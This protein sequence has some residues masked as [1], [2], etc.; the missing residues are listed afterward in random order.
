VTGTLASTGDFAVGASKFS[1]TAASGNT[2][3]SGDLTMSKSGSASTL[4][5]SGTTGLAITST[6]GYVDVE[7]VRFTGDDVGVA[8]KTDLLQLA[9]A[10]VTVDG[11]LAATGTTTLVAASL[12]GGVTMTAN[13]ATIT[14][15]GTTGLTISSGQY[16][17][18]EDLK[19]AGAVI[20]TGTS[21]T[22]LTIAATGASVTGT[23]SATGDVTVGT[24]GFVVTASNGNT[25]GKPFYLS[26]ETV[27]PIK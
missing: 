25:V 3:I 9:T 19:I 27:L 1:V 8:G 16:V 22:V 12:S 4:T 17:Q 26:S 11:T 13:A 15:S 23:L 6:A 21:A 5:H 14:H 18:V 7:S 2:A 20:G 10:G 24:A